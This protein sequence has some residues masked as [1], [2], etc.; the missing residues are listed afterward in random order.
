MKREDFRIVDVSCS[1]R[2]AIPSS[3]SDF[4]ICF[5]RALLKNDATN[6]Y[7]VVDVHDVPR[8]LP[9]WK[10]PICTAYEVNQAFL[11]QVGSTLNEKLWFQDTGAPIWGA[12]LPDH[13]GSLSYD[14]RLDACDMFIIFLMRR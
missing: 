3:D 1:N 13:S 11:D 4:P 10:T 14:S 6:K 2:K 9:L 12:G 7:Y 8:K 5:R